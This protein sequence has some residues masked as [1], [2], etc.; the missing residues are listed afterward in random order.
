MCITEIFYEVWAENSLSKPTY[1]Y[2][3]PPNSRRFCFIQQLFL[4]EGL[5]ELD[6]FGND[7]CSKELVDDSGQSVKQEK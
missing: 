6:Y 4:A 7:A 3:S 5:E 2:L 1:P